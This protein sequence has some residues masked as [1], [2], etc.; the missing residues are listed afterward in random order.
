MLCN[1]DQDIVP[2]DLLD[3]KQ[4]YHKTSNFN[5]KVP[6]LSL[7]PSRYSKKDKMKYFECSRRQIETAE[8]ATFFNQLSNKSNSGRKLDVQKATHFVD[9]LFMSSAIQETAHGTT[10]LRFEKIDSQRVS[11]AVLTVVRSHAIKLYLQYA[12]TCC[13]QPLSESSLWKIISELKLTQKKAL[14]GLYNVTAAVLSSI[15]ALIIIA[16]DRLTEV[17]QMRRNPFLKLLHI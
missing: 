6:I 4:T 8:K 17:T 2:D 9:F 13:F 12:E 3:L 1:N 11:K 7:V 15:S 5:E 10:M 16:K 14:S